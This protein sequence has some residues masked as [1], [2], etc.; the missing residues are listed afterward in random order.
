MSLGSE[1]IANIVS[2]AALVI[3][4]I[5]AVF[6]VRDRRHAKYAIE[7]EYVSQLL[8]WHAAVVEVLIEL[9]IL[10]GDGSDNRKREL[11][12]RLSA[13]IEQGRFYFPNIK[14]Q[15]YGLDKPPAYRGYRNLALDFLVA[16]YRLHQKPPSAKLA[17]QAKH[18]QQLFTSVI[19]EIVR[20][21]D[22]LNMIRELTDRYFVKELSAEDLEHED[23]LEAVSHI[24]KT[25]E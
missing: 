22:L 19:Y 5:L 6:Y 12:V 18:L 2:V 14:Q 3:S 10:S 16:S 25:Q 13:L 20:P 9:G 11:L 8:C 24:W 23:Q 21:M 15:E 7:N 17:I 4:A 1:Q